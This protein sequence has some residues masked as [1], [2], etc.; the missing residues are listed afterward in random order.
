MK[1][2]IMLRSLCSLEHLDPVLGPRR[3]NKRG[4]Q[5]GNKGKPASV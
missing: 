4:M 2:Q 1:K 5:A 3:A